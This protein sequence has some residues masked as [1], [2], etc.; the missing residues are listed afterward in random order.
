MYVPPPFVPVSS[1]PVPFLIL[2]K[3]RRGEERRE[4]EEGKKRD[5]GGVPETLGILATKV[6]LP[7][8]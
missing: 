4:A 6:K 5:E 2:I 8:P 3:K 1:V 7:F